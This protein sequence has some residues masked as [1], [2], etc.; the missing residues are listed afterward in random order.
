MLS[1]TELPPLKFN[2]AV[3]KL[4]FQAPTAQIGWLHSQ[5]AKPGASFDVTIR[6]ALGRIKME[7]KNCKSDTTDFGELV[8]TPTVIGE[9][10]EVEVSNLKGA[11]ELVLFLN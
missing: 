11:D 4:P 7:R 1:S 6:D 2:T 9:K 3:T 5:A 10:L 8:K